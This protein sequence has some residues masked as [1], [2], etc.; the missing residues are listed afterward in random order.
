MEAVHDQPAAASPASI[1][2]KHQSLSRRTPPSSRQLVHTALS[3][4]RDAYESTFESSFG[5]PASPAPPPEQLTWDPRGH[6]LESERS[7]ESTPRAGRLA[8][9]YEAW[10]NRKKAQVAPRDYPRSAMAPRSR[11]PPPRPFAAGPRFS[12]SAVEALG[13]VEPNGPLPPR[14]HLSCAAVVGYSGHIPKTQ[15][16]R[17]GLEVSKWSKASRAAAAPPRNA[18]ARTDGWAPPAWW[19]VESGTNGAAARQELAI[20]VREQRPNLGIQG[21]ADR[22]FRSELRGA[23]LDES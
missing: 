2:W 9:A 21:R 17:D 6:S 22:H 1:R 8:P 12:T 4:P 10:L 18:S 13:G 16:H 14:Q 3:G 7:L 15:D 23:W 11:P 20:D 5:V 19:H